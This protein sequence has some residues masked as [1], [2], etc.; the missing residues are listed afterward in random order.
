[1][2]RRYEIFRRL[3]IGVGL[4]AGAP[5]PGPH[6]SASMFFL[7]QKLKATMNGM[8]KEVTQGGPFNQYLRILKFS[9]LLV[10]NAPMKKTNQK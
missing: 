7:L 1:M 4:G 3:R 8:A 5:H 9:K 2:G 10:A 6:P